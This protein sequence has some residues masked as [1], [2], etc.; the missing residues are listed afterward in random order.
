MSEVVR[1]QSAE[2]R[3]LPGAVSLSR[4]ARLRVCAYY[5]L[6]ILIHL[7][8]HDY[9]AFTTLGCLHRGGDLAAGRGRG[10]FDMAPIWQEVH[11]VHTQRHTFVKH[12]GI[13]SACIIRLI[14]LSGR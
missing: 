6:T 5:R 12:V 4:P 9:M 8:L 1:V 10:P 14:W 3:P 13:N 7:D 2:L 11:G